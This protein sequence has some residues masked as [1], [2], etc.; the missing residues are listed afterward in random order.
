VLTYADVFPQ[1]TLKKIGQYSSFPA[2]QN[3]ITVTLATNLPISEGNIL[4]HLLVP[5]YNWYQSTN[6][7]AF[8][9]TKV[10]ILTHFFISE[11]L[12]LVIRGLT[13]SRSDVA[14]LA[15]TCDK[16]T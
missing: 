5:K 3:T 2:A 6:T 11:G 12:D 13:R 9:S 1:F 16:G 4:M 10:Q 14:T 7:D 15:I 8:T